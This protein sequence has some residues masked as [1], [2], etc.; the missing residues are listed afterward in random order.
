MNG[1]SRFR[2]I[3]KQYDKENKEIDSSI[4]QCHFKTFYFKESSIL[5][6]WWSRIY[7][8]IWKIFNFIRESFCLYLIL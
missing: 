3:L 7:D 4:G 8:M 2:L 5:K 6:K 1:E